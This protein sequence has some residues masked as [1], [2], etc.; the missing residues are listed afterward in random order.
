[1]FHLSLT[2]SMVS[3]PFSHLVSN[4]LASKM[5]DFNHEVNDYITGS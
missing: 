3:L 4:E 1:M 5:E 2:H